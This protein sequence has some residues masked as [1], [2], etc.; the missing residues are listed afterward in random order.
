MSFYA[1]FLRLILPVVIGIFFLH[2]TFVQAGIDEQARQAALRAELTQVEADI[3]KNTQLLQAKQKETASLKRDLDV[4]TYQIA[5]AKL[6]IREKQLAIQRLGTDIGKKEATVRDL[7]AKIDEEKESL[8]EL[9]RQTR[10]MDSTSVVEAALKGDNMSQIFADLNAFNYIQGSLNESFGE[11][12]RTRTDTELEK[13]GL[14]TK[15]DETIDAKAAIESETKKIQVLESRKQD[16]L[17]TSKSQES[18]YKRIL[19]DRQKKR[20]EIL[21]ALFSLRDTKA[22]PFER[23]LA[24][25]REASAKTGVRP[26]FILAIMTQETNLGANVGT[27]NRP[28]DPESKNWKNIMKPSRDIEPYLRITKGLGI[29]PDTMPLSCPQGSGYGGA[30]GPSQFIPSTW[31]LYQERIGDVTG[32]NPPNPW[33]AEDAFAATSLYLMDLGAGGATY[34]SESRAAG[35]YYAGSRWATAGKGYS[36]SVMAIA[37]KIQGNIDYLNN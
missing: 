34:S 18:N 19:A 32:H 23:A 6:K 16:L 31:E 33:E 28:G 15:R 3:A 37:E 17:K 9:L 20:S 21:S 24:F 11:I 35:K 10:E 12:K 26:A 30:M 13:S 29:A 27:C 25:A 4:L 1:P 22:I 2:P 8:A 14:E 7:S 36:N 5:T